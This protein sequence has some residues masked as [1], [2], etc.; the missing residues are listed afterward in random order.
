MLARNADSRFVKFVIDDVKRMQLKH[1]NYRAWYFNPTRL[2]HEA[3][4]D[5]YQRDRQEHYANPRTN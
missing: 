5:R 3:R 2:A 4:A 1:R